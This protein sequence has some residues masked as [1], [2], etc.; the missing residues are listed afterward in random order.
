MKRKMAGGSREKSATEA[1]RSSPHENWEARAYPQIDVTFCG[2]SLQIR[3]P[4]RLHN[5]PGMSWN[6][7]YRVT[8]V[9]QE[10]LLRTMPNYSPRT[11]SSASGLFGH[12]SSSSDG[13]QF[14]DSE[15]FFPFS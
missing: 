12:A 9:M 13:G 7:L 5:P 11:K 1:S 4:I 2:R 10:S 15:D 8:S 3:E 6:H 14:L